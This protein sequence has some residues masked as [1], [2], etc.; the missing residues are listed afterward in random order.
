MRC[1]RCGGELILTNVVRDA[2]PGV[3]HHTFVCAECHVT[4]QRVLLMRHG[5]EDEGA[6]IPPAKPSRPAS[7]AEEPRGAQ[8][9]FGRLMARMR[10]H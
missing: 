9:L 3:E 4:E 10:R 8:G 1:T 7:T 5:R 6:P 2:A